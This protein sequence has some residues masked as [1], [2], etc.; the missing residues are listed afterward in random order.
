M[1]VALR[2]LL[3]LGLPLVCAGL[4]LAYAWNHI[5]G[6]DG[7]WGGLLGIAIIGGF[8]VT[9]FAFL[10]FVL[11]SDLPAV[12]AILAFA[13]VLA[14]FVTGAAGAEAYVLYQ[15][16]SDVSCQVTSITPGLTGYATTDTLALAC[17]GGRPSAITGNGEQY[18][19][20]T[21]GQ[22]ISV[23]FDPAGNATTILS[24]DASDGHVLLTIAAV[25]FLVLL[26]QG[27]A[28]AVR[29]PVTTS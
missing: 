19:D 4:S 17:D 22:Q 2:I 8:L 13:G 28:T 24:S 20:I 26:A 7:L 3:G 27:V 12:G 9:G 16:G 21:V 5:D 15:R 23:R 6:S 10:I 1:R 29:R 18:D 14:L 25:S 11:S